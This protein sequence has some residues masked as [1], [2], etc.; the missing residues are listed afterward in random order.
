MRALSL[1][2][3]DALI[4]KGNC[5]FKFMRGAKEHLLLPVHPPERVGEFAP[6]SEE[7]I[8]WHALFEHSA[9]TQEDTFSC[10]KVVVAISP[11]AICHDEAHF[12]LCVGRLAYGACVWLL[13]L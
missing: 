8:R 7:Q 5:F 10:L 2:L 13:H 11:D 12:R 9:C 6:C 1:S 4:V 3:I